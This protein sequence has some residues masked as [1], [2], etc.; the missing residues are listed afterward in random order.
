MNLIK[1]TA[2]H[3]WNLA[4]LL[5]STTAVWALV[6]CGTTI[7]GGGQ[8]TDLD[9]TVQAQVQATVAALPTATAPV[10][11]T[12]ALTPAPMPTATPKP[13]PTPTPTSTPA[14]KPPPTAVQTPAPTPAP[15]PTPDPSTPIFGP[16]SGAIIHEPGDRRFEVF[17]GVR[18]GE[19]VMVEV[20]FF[21]PYPTTW[22]S[23][24]YGLLLRNALPNF[25]H[26][27]RIQSKGS[28]AHSIRL[29]N[30]VSRVDLR[31]ELSSNVDNTAGGRNHLRFIMIGDEGWVYINGKFQGNVDLR[32]LTDTSPI[33]LVLGDRDEK[34]GEATRFEDFTIWKWH[35]D[36]ASLPPTPAAT[37]VP[38]L[39][40]TPDPA[41]PYY[42]PI[43][44]SL[45]HNPEDENVPTFRGPSIKDAM[46]EATFVNPFP[47]SQNS[48]SY[49]FL[50]RS[51]SGNTF[52]A[53]I[54]RHGSFWEHKL[55]LGDVSGTL[56][57]R[58]ANSTS[59]DNST[60][61]ENTLRVVMVGD[62]GWFFLN[63][64]FV[65]NLDL[66]E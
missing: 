38:T 6:A 58:A 5:F 44:A 54:V 50:L 53:I 28:W 47:A 49:G 21:N 33:S 40:P 23:W 4:A 34:E 66:R 27:V 8:A 65:S 13:V 3:P 2:I 15:T 56:D 30:E 32:G 20:T 14:T 9:A 24:S 26:W 57:L 10:P 52:H 62:E 46:V 39:T 25:Y 51:L 1:V 55:R 64:D 37:A 7:G 29:G 16:I 18:T 12:A 17:K 31:S 43:V 42:G 41:V 11:P 61:G 60:D 45:P 59:I 19:D 63:G 35:P 48:W 36:L 22:G